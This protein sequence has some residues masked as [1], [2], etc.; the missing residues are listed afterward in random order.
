MDEALLRV[1]GEP[2]NY[3]GYMGSSRS[4]A[5]DEANQGRGLC[6]NLCWLCTP[7]ESF[8]RRQTPER[9]DLLEHQPNLT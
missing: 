1:R 3:T 5:T 6:V 9:W 7:F 8:V 4:Q 2:I